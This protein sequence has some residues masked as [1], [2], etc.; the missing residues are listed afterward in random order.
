MREVVEVE[1]VEVDEK[2]WRCLMSIITSFLREH[3]PD[4]MRPIPVW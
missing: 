2:W 4:S 3:M 1:E